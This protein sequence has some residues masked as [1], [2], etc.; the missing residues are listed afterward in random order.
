MRSFFR[1]Q[2][3]RT[4]GRFAKAED[5]T[6]IV[7]LGFAVFVLVGAAGLAFDAWR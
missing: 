5:G 4:I 3:R 7:L 6:A 1:S 2:F